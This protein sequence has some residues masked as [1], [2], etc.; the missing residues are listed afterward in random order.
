[1]NEPYQRVSKDNGVF[2]GAL[3][4]AAVGAGG[5]TA[6]VFGTRMHYGGIEKRQQRDLKALNN[7]KTYLEGQADRI[8][9]K[10]GS[11]IDKLEGKRMN[12]TKRQKKISKLE[13]KW[14]K[15]VGAIESKMH[16][17]DKDLAH[18]SN[19]EG[20]KNKHLYSKM[21]GW[22]NAAIIG[23]SAVVGGGVGMIADELNK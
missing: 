23:A 11:K 8:G 14:D 2:D 20:L 12:E 7:Q 22:R 13:D 18:V 15:K 9:D 10:L 1:M 4:G 3:I 5:A 21:G 16:K 19:L 17:V 6:G